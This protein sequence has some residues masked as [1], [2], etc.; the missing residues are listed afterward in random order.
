MDIRIRKYK[1]EYGYSYALG[2]APAMELVSR[3]RESVYK[4]YLSPDYRPA[5]GSPDFR[6]MGLP[7]ETN[8]RVFER[9]AQKE[10]VFV[11]GA[12]FKFSRELEKERPHV[13][14]ADISDMGNLGTIIRTALGFGVSDI[15]TIGLASADFFD[16]KAI[17]AS[18]GAVFG[19]RLKN[20]ADFESYRREF[21]GQELYPFMLNGEHNLKDISASGKNFSLIFGNEA[22]GL[23][24]AFRKMG[25]SVFIEH[26]RDID[27][28]NLSVA[29]GIALYNFTSSNPL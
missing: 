2:A 17:R 14:L 15:A 29:A 5:L 9:V 4:I 13:V 19:A 20:F 16:P 10:N 11:I 24:E 18:M 3:A 23:P 28:L 25:K 1:K 6:G 22:R 21:P 27:S 8:A 7:W 26:G 12:F